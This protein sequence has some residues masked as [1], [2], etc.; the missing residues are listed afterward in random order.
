MVPGVGYTESFSPLAMDTTVRTS[1]AMALYCQKEGWTIEMFDIEAA[2][3][4]TELE[5]DQ[6]AFADG[7][8]RVC[9]EILVLSQKTNKRRIVS[10]LKRA[11]YGGVNVPRLFHENA[12]ASI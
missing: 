8:R 1:I 2:F 4:N 11:M 3:L 12:F 10:E 6:P 5:S 7:P 9:L